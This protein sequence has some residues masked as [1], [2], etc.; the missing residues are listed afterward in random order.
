MPNPDQ[1]ESNSFYT[2]VDVLHEQGKYG[3]M[4]RVY[5]KNNRP[6]IYVLIPNIQETPKC[7]IMS[8]LPN[9]DNVVAKLSYDTKTKNINVKP[10]TNFK[11]FFDSLDIT[12]ENCNVKIPLSP[13]MMMLP[14][15]NKLTDVALNKATSRNYHF[16]DIE[17]DLWDQPK[18]PMAEAVQE[19]WPID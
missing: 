8:L 17:L 12:K 14:Y 9:A 19:S 15:L 1:G 18:N 5:N 16:E 11:N 4:R 13:Q 2:L 10:D 7:F 3:I 6:K